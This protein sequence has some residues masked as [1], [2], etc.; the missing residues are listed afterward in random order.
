MNE[1][2]FL[3]NLSKLRGRFCVKP[4]GIIRT[5][6]RHGRDPYKSYLC[7]IEELN[8]VLSG[9]NIYVD[10]AAENLNINRLLCDTIVEAS[11]QT[12]SEL[13]MFEMSG[14]PNILSPLR[15]KMLKVLGLK[16]KSVGRN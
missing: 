3:R 8:R 16:E 9:K 1:R 14:S 7:P 5:R 13:E 10:E 2:T 12:I 15:K 4:S 11:D 6:N